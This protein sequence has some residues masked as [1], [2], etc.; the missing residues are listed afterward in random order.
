VH[1]KEVVMKWIIVILIILSAGWMFADG[2]RALIIGDYVTPTSGDYAGELGPWAGLLQSVGL[3]PRSTFIKTAFVLYGAVSLIAVTGFALEQPWSR[4]F[5]IVMAVMGL[6]YLPIG[7]AT[8]MIALI[9]LFLFR[10]SHVTRTP[11]P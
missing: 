8:N 10:R 7:T 9:L 4:N 5:L 6:W 1:F 2:L 3:E 11:T